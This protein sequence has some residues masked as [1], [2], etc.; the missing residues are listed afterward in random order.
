[1]KTNLSITHDAS[2]WPFH[3]WAEF[4]LMPDRDRRVVII[5]VVGMGDW[6]FEAP[7]DFE[8]CLAL[9]ILKDALGKASDT[10]PF[11]VIPPV[12]FTM[13]RPGQSYFTV[14]AETAHVTLEDIVGSIQA[15]GF[16][17]ILFYNSS[18]W[19][20][21]LVDATGRDLRIK[22]GVQPFCINLSSLGL[23]FQSEEMREKFVSL[24]D[25]IFEAGSPMANQGNNLLQEAGTEL[26][27][28]LKEV[29]AFRPLPN[30]GAIPQKSFPL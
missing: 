29:H 12:R 21:D 22:L 2:F 19:N 20:E 23:D 26:L 16:R 14:D 3:T 8:E 4:S 6:G 1:M 25:H 27:S 30:D 13:G 11:L 18:P 24:R 5:P 15:Q 10:T 28:L 7:L 17:K 9:S